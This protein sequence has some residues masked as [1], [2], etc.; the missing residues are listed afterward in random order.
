MWL[1]VSIL[2]VTEMKGKV[3]PPI[4][5]M[6]RKL[7]SLVYGGTVAKFNQAP[8]DPSSSNG[9]HKVVE[10]CFKLYYLGRN[11]KATHFQSGYIIRDGVT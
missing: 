8:L 3:Q 7:P 4:P 5:K 9:V 11:C 1:E 10:F 2:N 6:A